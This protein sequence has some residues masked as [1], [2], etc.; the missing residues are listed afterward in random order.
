MMKI[1]NSKWFLKEINKYTFFRLLSTY[2]SGQP[3]TVMIKHHYTLLTD[4]TVARS[5]RFNYLG[6]GNMIDIY[7]ILNLYKFEVYDIK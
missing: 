2:A 5:Q 1:K 6:E 7:I 4:L 3:R